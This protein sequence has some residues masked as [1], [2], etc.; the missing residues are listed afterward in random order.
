MITRNETD[1]NAGMINKSLVLESIGKIEY[2]ETKIPEIH[3]G[4]VLIRVKAAGICGSD[5]PRAYKTGAHLM[6]I[7]PGH[8]FSGVVESVGKNVSSAWIGKRV[9]V[10]PKIACG[11][12]E[13]CK[14]GNP[15]SC[16]QYDYIGS[17]RDG[18]FAEYVT[19]PVGNLLKLP[20]NVSFE[21]AAMFEPLGVA[22]NAV[23]T[24]LGLKKSGVGC[25]Q[26]GKADPE[27][28]QIDKSKTFVICG[29]GTIGLLIA[30]LLKAE[31]FTKIYGIGN[32]ESQKKRFE[33]LG[34]SEGFFLQ[35]ADQ[36]AKEPADPDFKENMCNTERIKNITCG[37]ADYYFE[38]VGKNECISQGIE[39]VGP[40]GTVVLVG[41]P[42]SDMIFEKNVYW[43]IL[44]EQITL[45]GIWNS[46]FAGEPSE[47]YKSEL[48]ENQTSDD[49]HYVLS[50]MEEG[51]IKP[52]KLITHRF[53]LEEAYKG[54]ELM[55]DKTEDYCKV[56]ILP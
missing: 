4:E 46:E 8:E 31:G 2:R 12:C 53:S 10:F 30:M 37:G 3:D 11:K 19:A 22:A 27:I 9:S 47:E 13:Q 17:R 24:A 36:G 38:C 44:R 7:I 32:K 1:I 56:M 28:N 6:P 34:I 35:S 48:T 18:A 20:E 50:L 23:R 54:F 43:K 51:K 15:G 14:K 33:A 49:W 42:Y 52:G 21:E 25:L 39:S 40:G 29:M 16:T 41:N 5:I 55:R 26:T 45:K